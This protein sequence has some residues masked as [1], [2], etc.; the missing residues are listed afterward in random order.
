M[1]TWWKIY[2]TSPVVNYFGSIKE[3]K[4]FDRGPIFIGGCA[5]SGTSL[6]LSILSSHPSIF[7][8]PHEVDAHTTWSKAGEHSEP[9]RLDRL[10]RYLLTH[11]IEASAR[12]WCE[13]RPFNVRYIPEIL[14]Y[15]GSNS[16]FIHIVRDPRSVCTSVHPEASDRYWVSIDRWVGDV[17]K[18]LESQE[19]K[20]VYTLRF[21]DLVADDEAEIRK[22]CQ[23]LGEEVEDQILRWYL[24]AK[25]RSNRAWFT[26]LKDLSRL[27]EQKWNAPEHSNRLEE[28]MGNHEVLE[29]MNELG[30][31]E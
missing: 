10:Y 3:K 21:E 11:K 13:K 31:H 25:V 6:L 4:C 5:R 29:L 26:D 1:N 12:R 17:S 19:H 24:F 2:L 28:I 14:S 22:L 23:F 16:R 15:Y 30:Y 27:K 20:Q 8:F 18:G 9:Q 7:C